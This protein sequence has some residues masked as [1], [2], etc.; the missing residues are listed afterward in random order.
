M[1]DQIKILSKETLIPVGVLLAILLPFA[2]AIIF[3]V[4][5]R[6]DTM[7]CEEVSADN[8]IRVVALEVE[9]NAIKNTVGKFETKL[10]Y[11]IQIVEEI[12]SNTK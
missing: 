6:N 5:L 3:G 10:D 7:R 2:T 1:T 12:K 9:M 8:K 4:N 11:L